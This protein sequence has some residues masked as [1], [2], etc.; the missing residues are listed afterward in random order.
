MSTKVP[1]SS[2]LKK[3]LLVFFLANVLITFSW[4]MFWTPILSFLRLL[5]LGRSPTE[6]ITSR[7]LLYPTLLVF[8]NIFPVVFSSL[9]MY[10]LS[11]GRIA[12]VLISL[13]GSSLIIGIDYVV[14]YWVISILSH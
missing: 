10:L 3:L 1:K 14:L 8:V 11:R 13:I 2:N 4:L 9:V 7:T 6:E 5:L 12:L